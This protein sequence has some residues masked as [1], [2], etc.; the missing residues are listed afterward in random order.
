MKLRINN[1][2]V[3]FVLFLFIVTSGAVLAFV[4]GKVGYGFVIGSITML[5][6]TS[7]PRKYRW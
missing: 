5:I 1:R 4:I 6:A 2:T 3:S 7:L